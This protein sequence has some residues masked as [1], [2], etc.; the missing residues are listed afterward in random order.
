MFVLHA[1]LNYNDVLFH[2]KTNLLNFILV[3]FCIVLIVKFPLKPNA[4]SIMTTQ[5]E[6]AYQILKNLRTEF[7]FGIISSRQNHCD[8]EQLVDSWYTCTV[9][10]GV[11]F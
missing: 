3:L 1:E 8:R 4:N 9:T 7:I 6:L 5:I 2:I 11:W 10:F